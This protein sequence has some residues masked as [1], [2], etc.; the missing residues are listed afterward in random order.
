M[1]R[2]MLVLAAMTRLEQ[3][4]DQIAQLSSEEF[5]R[6][7]DWIMEKDWAEWDRQIEEDASA[8][9]LDALAARALKDHAAGKSRP[10]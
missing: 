3:L 8:G 1:P 6:L 7:R 5:A 2:C 4:E 10:I 9:K